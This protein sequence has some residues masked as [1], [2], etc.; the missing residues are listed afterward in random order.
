VV[1]LS[2]KFH[3]AV[4]WA[5]KHQFHVGTQEEQE[6]YTL[7][8]TII[9]NA[10]ILWNYLALSAQ[11]VA[12]GDAK[13]KQDM[14]TTIAQGSVLTWRYVNFTGEYEFTKPPRGRQPFPL[15]RIQKLV[16]PV[17]EEDAGQGD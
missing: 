8:R 4:F 12:L 14:A 11:Y 9:Q 15:A 3:D 13:A 1:E 7:C 2:N 17:A 6:K 10:V 16:L 5:R